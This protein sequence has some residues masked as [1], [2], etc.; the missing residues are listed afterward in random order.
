MVNSLEANQFKQYVIEQANEGN[1]FPAKCLQQMREYPVDVR[2]F[3][4]SPKYLNEPDFWPTALDT[5]EELCNNG[6]NRS[7]SP[8]SEAVL[9]GSIGSGKSFL[10]CAA[11]AYEVY[12]LV[13]CYLE[14]QKLFGLSAKSD[15]VFTF[16]SPTQALSEKVGFTQFRNFILE[17]ECFKGQFAP[18]HRKKRELRWK[19]GV[20]V[21]FLSGSENSALGMNVFGGLMDEVSYGAFIEDSKKA[22]DKDIY[23]QSRAQYRAIALRRKS[24]FEFGGQ[25]PG[26]L[27]L[28]SSPRTPE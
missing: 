8:Y 19:N 1:L 25:L 5:L 27:F 14:P 16:Q 12:K 2:T 18:D 23:D 7:G 21:R 17:A 11:L 28:V 3:V 9:C 4:T 20:V 22:E 6:G 24:R 26:L 10:A 13:C 15:I